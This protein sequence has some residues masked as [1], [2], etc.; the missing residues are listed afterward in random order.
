MAVVGEFGSGFVIGYPDIECG[1][2]ELE[3]TYGGAVLER[4]AARFAP[5]L[6]CFLD[7]DWTRTIQEHWR[8]HRPF[9]RNGE[10]VL[11]PIRRP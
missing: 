5:E 4:R 8:T 1:Q 2:R 7:S 9:L 3:V 11:E 10:L 6:V